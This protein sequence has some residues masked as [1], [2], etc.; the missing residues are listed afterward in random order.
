MPQ[1][2][3]YLNSAFNAML[4]GSNALF[5]GKEWLPL[6]HS[7]IK[8]H[9]FDDDVV[10]IFMPVV[11]EYGG[12]AASAAGEEKVKPTGELLVGALVTAQDRAILAWSKGMIRLK[13][14]SEV[15]PYATVQSV[16]PFTMST[17]MERLPAFEVFTTDGTRWPF[18]FSN[19]L[20][21]KDVDITRWRDRMVH[22]FEG[23][24]P[25]FDGADVVR[26]AAPSR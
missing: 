7:D 6:I 22:R 15:L 11:F 4:N 26:W 25:E 17:K 24:R 8:P 16:A 13:S 18:T 3:D 9:L 23:W 19:N 5:S 20:K 21:Y 14:F 10:D 12:S 2:M 1:M